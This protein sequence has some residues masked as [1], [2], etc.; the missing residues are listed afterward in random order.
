[1]PNEV[2]VSWRVIANQAPNGTARYLPGIQRYSVSANITPF[3][4]RSVTRTISIAA[5]DQ[6]TVDNT[7]DTGYRLMTFPYSFAD[8]RPGSALV[9]SPAA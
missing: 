9:A 6:V 4:S 1:K 8:Q 2:S 7:L 5:T 3:G